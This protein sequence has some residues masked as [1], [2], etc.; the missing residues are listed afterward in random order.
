VAPAQ[1]KTKIAVIGAIGLPVLG[2]FISLVR[3]R[4]EVGWL[5]E[6]VILAQVFCIV[7]CVMAIDALCD[8]R[9]RGVRRTRRLWWFLLLALIAWSIE[10]F[11][12]FV[13]TP[14]WK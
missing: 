9:K 1:Q 7:G 2:V 13:F 3:A 4:I 6:I 10:L 5:R 12:R 11:V 8:K 14:L